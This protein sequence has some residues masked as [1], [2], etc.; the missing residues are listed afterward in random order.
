META[1]LIYVSDFTSLALGDFFNMWN[2]FFLLQFKL[3][4]SY[5]E[6]SSL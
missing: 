6:S 3:I 1:H 5:S 2:L 4:I